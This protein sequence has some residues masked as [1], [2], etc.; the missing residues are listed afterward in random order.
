MT[1][2][3][4]GAAAGEGFD[5]LVK[6]GT[7]VTSDTTYAAD[8]GVIDGRIVAIAFP[9]SLGGDARQ[10]LD[11]SGRYVLPGVID[12]HVH[13]REPG[14]EYKEDFLTGSRAA[15]MGGVTTVLE[16]PN[17][18]PTTSTADRVAQ[19]LQ[20]ALGKSYC[21]F[22]LFG[23]LV[24]DSV[25]HLRGM[26]EAGVVGFKCFLGRS[27]GEITPPDDGMLLDGLSVIA[28]L[29]MRCGFHAEN[30][31]IMQHAVRKLKAAGRS[32]PLAHLESRPVLAEVESIQRAALFASHT[33]TKMHIFHLSS[34]RGLETIEEWRAKGVDITC[35]A[36][37]HHCFLTSEDMRELGPILRI[38]P[39]V[40]EPGHAEA[41]LD[42]LASGRVTSIATDHSPHLRS[43]KMHDDIWQAV[44]GFAGVEISLR[45][46][47]T[48]G[49]KAERLSLQQ[50]VRATSE[51]PA[52]TW[53][54]FPRKG[55]IAVGSDAD[56]TIVDLEVED[57]IEESRLHGKNNLTPFEGHRTRGAAVATVV[58]GHV[59]MQDGNLLG[60]PQGQ[61]VKRV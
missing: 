50:L 56:L 1:A 36:A 33:G 17:T 18:L 42:G 57:T 44:S 35:E 23:L 14:L 31:Q 8:L 38:N 34:R 37:P 25:E 48:Y 4:T 45:L 6:G 51:G 60:S 53:G 22:G 10:V 28:E 11:A 9:G 47:L 54:L 49:V 32:D 46:F 2:A 19:K 12:G 13:F 59:V 41:L 61:M 7:L 52:R 16:M 40:R 29:E 21:D 5:L 27:T 20:L 55:A 26:A 39:P 30:D 24:Q 43:E 15:V 3:G 58:R